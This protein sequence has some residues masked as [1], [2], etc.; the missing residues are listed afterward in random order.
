MRRDGLTLIT[1]PMFAGKSARLVA[2]IEGAVAGGRG[3]VLVLKP[4][5]D[6]RTDNEIFSR[7]GCSYPARPVSAW[8]EDAGAYRTIV[9][10]E[11]HFWTAPHYHGDVVADIEGMLAAGVDVVAGGLDTDYRRRPFEVM[12]RLSALADE[13][14]PLEARCHVCG[15]AARWTAKRV[16]TG[17]L[18]ETGDA[19]L[20][21]A[22]CD[23]HFTMPEQAA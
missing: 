16:E 5:F 3:P 6:T 8:P 4:A 18:L 10:D 17:H 19:E 21:E 22:R 23:L 12:M 13:C 7:A 14:V 20:Y 2:A 15:A 9:L 11:A 1:G